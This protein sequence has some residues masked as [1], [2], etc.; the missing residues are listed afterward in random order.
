MNASNQLEAPEVASATGAAPVQA[1]PVSRAP[2]YV[3]AMQLLQRTSRRKRALISVQNTARNVWLAGILVAILAWLVTCWWIGAWLKFPWAAINLFNFVNVLGWFASSNAKQRAAAQTL[4]ALD[5]IAV[6]GAMAD[7]LE[8]G[9]NDAEKEEGVRPVAE[10]ALI[11]LLPRLTPNDS[12]LLDAEQR[13]C[14][15][16]ALE[17]ENRDLTVA[18]LRALAQVGDEGAV[19]PLETFLNERKDEELRDLGEAAL[20]ASRER[21]ERDRAASTLLR[22]ASMQSPTETLLRPAGS[23]G[24]SDAGKLLRPAAT[25]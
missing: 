5:N 21:A 23:A 6:V 10:A 18:I 4:A 3:H 2:A 7:A 12:H 24:P 16:R 9:M 25:E 8:A 20:T 1:A 14:L 22:A 19:R 13:G 17:G 15:Y 11:R